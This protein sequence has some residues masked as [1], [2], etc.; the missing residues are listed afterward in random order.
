MSIDNLQGNRSLVR[1]AVPGVIVT[2]AMSALA[3]KGAS[4]APFP[5]SQ[6]I[7]IALIQATA[8]GTAITAINYTN[9]NGSFS[10][11]KRPNSWWQSG[12]IASAT[13]GTAGLAMAPFISAAVGI[14]LKQAMIGAV[15]VGVGQMFMAG[16]GLHFLNR[17]RD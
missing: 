7:P 12:L 4:S 16:V 10:G 14:P 9:H 3:I 13:F 6:F 2:G 1:A 5:K 17:P 8:W 15:S 11:G